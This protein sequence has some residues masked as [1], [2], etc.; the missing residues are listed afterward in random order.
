MEL[1]EADRAVIQKLNLLKRDLQ[2]FTEKLID[3]DMD[4][5][6]HKI[7]I[8]ALHKLDSNRKCHRLV[9]GILVERNVAQVLPSLQ[10]NLEAVQLVV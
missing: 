7:V 2:A 10:S 3:L 4:Q 5:D 1:S 9:G 6:E 8:E